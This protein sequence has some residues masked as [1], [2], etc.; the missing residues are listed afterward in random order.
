[1]Q[2]GQLSFKGQSNRGTGRLCLVSMTHCRERELFTQVQRS[3]RHSRCGELQASLPLFL[4]TISTWIPQPENPPASPRFFASSVA[5]RTGLRETVET[6]VQ[7]KVKK[8]CSCACLLPQTNEKTDFPTCC[9]ATGQQLARISILPMQEKCHDE[10]PTPSIRDSVFRTFP[11]KRPRPLKK[12][13]SS[14]GVM[15]FVGTLPIGV[16]TMRGVFDS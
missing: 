4:G 7:V 2:E 13:L 5:V 11:T 9:G 6:R 16:V 1:M 8:N 10:C 14:G 12:R 3:A 15:P